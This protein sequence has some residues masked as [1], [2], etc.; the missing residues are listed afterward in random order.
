MV[1]GCPA[2]ARLWSCLYQTYPEFY[3]FAGAVVVGFFLV[4]RRWAPLLLALVLV[5][6][7]LLL[8]TWGVVR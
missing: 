4:W 3:Y 6:T 7:A 8:R 1:A 2:D 5:G